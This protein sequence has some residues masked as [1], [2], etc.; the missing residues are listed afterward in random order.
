MIA[1]DGLGQVKIRDDPRLVAAADDLIQP[2][3]FQPIHFRLLERRARDDLREELDRLV[4]NPTQ[5]GEAQNRAVVSHLDVQARPNEV[6]GLS[7]LVS[8]SLFRP[9]REGSGG[10]QSRPRPVAMILGRAGWDHEPDRDLGKIVVTNR[11][12]R[13]PIAERQALEARQLNLRRRPRDRSPAAI[14]RWRS[15]SPHSAS[16]PSSDGRT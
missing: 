3:V 16:T 2:L 10:E 7:D 4:K 15:P 1:E 14:E 9:L 8:G 6:E 5:K 13:Q 12:E 11:E